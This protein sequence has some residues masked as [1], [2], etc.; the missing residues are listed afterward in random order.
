MA[1]RISELPATT[2]VEAITGYLEGA[3]LA[4]KLIEHDRT[5]SAFSEARATRHPAEQVAK[6][7]VLRN[8][9]VDVLAVVP[10]S[11]RLDLHRVREL[12][13]I[14]GR[15][16]RLATEHELAQDFPTLEVGAIPP[17]GPMV[18][19]AELFDVRLLEYSRIVCPAGDHAHSVLVD[20]LA[21]VELTAAR[22]ADV[23]QR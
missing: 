14:S 10:A 6:T 13:G 4:Y 20:P 15:G 11:R 21:V 22:V 5:T 1:S 19:T 3:G 8:G 12:L 16:L 18:P 2:R 23:C 17:F 9:I 7:V